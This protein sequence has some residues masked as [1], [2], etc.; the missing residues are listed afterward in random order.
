MRKLDLRNY[1]A[2][3]GQAFEVRPSLVAIL[4]N[5]KYDPRELIARDRLAQRIEAAPDEFILLEET[6]FARLMSGLEAT[7]LSGIGRS[8]TPFCQR[9]LDTATV[10]VQEK[11]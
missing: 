4:F 6:D 5:G 3:N 7:D 9:L 8:A 10:D 11:Q 2:F 1:T